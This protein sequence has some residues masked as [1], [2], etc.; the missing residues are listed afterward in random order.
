MD[1]KQLYV[2]S[3]E[4]EHGGIVTLSV[5]GEKKTVRVD[6]R[7]M[8]KVNKWVITITDVETEKVIIS[9]VPLISSTAEQ[10]NDIL[11]QH[12][13]LIIGKMVVLP[14]DEKNAGENPSKDTF[15]NFAIVWGG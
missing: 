14:K 15:N 5:N 11:G 9:N 8:E 1:W 2:G 4:K 13:Y 10:P 7:L 3:N 12:E 6:M